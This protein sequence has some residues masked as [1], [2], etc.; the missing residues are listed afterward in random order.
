MSKKETEA[1]MPLSINRK[2]EAYFWDNLLK[3]E[4]DSK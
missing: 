4:S 2:R 3:D 1:L